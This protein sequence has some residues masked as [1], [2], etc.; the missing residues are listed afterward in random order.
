MTPNQVLG[1]V[2][3]QDT[4]RV[5]RDGGIQEEE[6]KKKSVAFK[7]GTSSSKSKGKA[8]KEESSEDEKEG[9]M[10]ED[11]EMALFVRRFD[12]FMK[13]GYGARRRKDKTKSKDEPRGC[14]KCKSKDHLIADCPNNS[15]NDEDEKK[16]KKDKKEKKMTFKKKGHLL[17]HMG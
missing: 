13:K 5:E 8:K 6:K 1:D 10:D 16:E 12:K 4:Y 15:D 3:T 2:V 14:Y 11:E 9:S 7:A 17:C